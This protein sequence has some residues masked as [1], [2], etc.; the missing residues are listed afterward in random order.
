[1]TI[2]MEMGG[3]CSGL[4]SWVSGAFSGLMVTRC[5]GVSRIKLYRCCWGVRIVGMSAI[6]EGLRHNACLLKIVTLINIVASFGNCNLL[7]LNH[8]LIAFRALMVVI[9]RML[10]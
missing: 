5:G 9:L 4:G 10:S 7:R 2:V 1:M 3:H 8:L 6:Q